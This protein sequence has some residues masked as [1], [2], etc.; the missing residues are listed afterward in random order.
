MNKPPLVRTAAVA[1][2]PLGLRLYIARSTPN[3]VRAEQNL[4][5]ALDE[6]DS[7]GVR[8]PLEIVDVFTNPKR[9][10][11]DGVIVT[12]TLFGLTPHGRTTMMGDLT[13]TAKLRV[14]LRTLQ[15]DSGG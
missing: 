9:A 12:P 1:P 2:S 4:R 5:A 11:N 7:H 6:F 15:D 14:L 10:L 13:D 3:S 8:L